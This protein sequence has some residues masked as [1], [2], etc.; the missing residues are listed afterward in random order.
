MAD[1]DGGRRHSRPLSADIITDAKERAEAEARNG[2]RQFDAALELIDYWLQPDR[3][4]RLRVSHILHLHRIALEGIS[5][6]AGNFRP[7]GV[8]IEGSEHEPV[9]A[10]LV[11]GR[12]EE[13]CDYV[14]DNWTESS[15]IHLAAYVMWRLNWIHPFADGNGRTSRALSYVVLCV[16]LGYKLPGT[17]TIPY[18]I[19]RNRKPYFDALDKADKTAK[20]GQLNLRAME[21]LL[22][23]LLG[24]QLYDVVQ[25][26]AGGGSGRD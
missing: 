4:F 23:E 19:A 26:A 8:E 3:P 2:L 17:K 14:N 12:V 7:G 20:Q 21:D 24:E 16:K 22:E 15:A 6:Y 25:Q 10:H 9:P 5:L 13:L 11:P 1:E 18:Q